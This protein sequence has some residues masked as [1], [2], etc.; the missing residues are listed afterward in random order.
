LEKTMLDYLYFHPELKESDD[1]DGKRFNTE[2]LREK[3]DR[4]KLENYLAMFD[5]PNL[6][7]RTYAFLRYL[8]A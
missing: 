2:V 4:E 5:S 8:Y 1:F 7:K 3:L 6:E